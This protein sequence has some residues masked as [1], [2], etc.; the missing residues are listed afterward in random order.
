T[1]IGDTIHVQIRITR[2]NPINYV[3]GPPMPDYIGT[4]FIQE[5][6]ATDS[7]TTISNWLHPNID[8][9]IGDPINLTYGGEDGG[10]FYDRII[11][12]IDTT[13]CKSI[14]A[15]SIAGFICLDQSLD[16]N[17]WY[18]QDSIRFSSGDFPVLDSLAVGRLPFGRFRSQVIDSTDEVTGIFVTA[19]GQR[20][21]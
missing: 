4:F 7:T 19:K 16:R 3:F 5:F 15:D 6:G 20:V 17:T 10:G 18:P 8:H 11:M 12:Q 1:E 14:D 21:K 9:V 2:I 13:I